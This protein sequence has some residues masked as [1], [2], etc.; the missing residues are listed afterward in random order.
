VTPLDRHIG[1][2]VR[3]KRRALGL[4]ADDLARALGVGHHT[5]EAYE[6]GTMRVEREHLIKLAEF[7]GVSVSY[8]F[9]MTQCPG[10][11]HGNDPPDAG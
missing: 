1:R 4:T 11:G 3:G 10:T 8:F 6:R 7:L 5:I 2:R 9:P